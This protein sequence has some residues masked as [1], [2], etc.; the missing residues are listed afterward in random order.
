MG[1]LHGI[2][3]KE[4]NCGFKVSLNSSFSITFALEALVV[5][6][7]GDARSDTSL[8]P[9]QGLFAFLIPFGKRMNPTILL[10]VMVN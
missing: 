2:R 5:I 10:P 1:S 7:I 3:T 4:L 6:I 8:N 9:G